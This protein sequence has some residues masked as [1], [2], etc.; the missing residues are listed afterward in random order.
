MR[1]SVIAVTGAS[2]MVGSAL[3]AQLTTGGHRVVRLVR[4]DPR[5]PGERRWDPDGPAPGLLDGT[6]AVVHLA[7]APIAGRF[8]DAHKAAVRDSRVGPT[9]RLAQAAARAQNGPGV[10][11]SA[12]AIGYYGHHRTGELLDE[13]ASPGA[14][15]L[16]GV[17]R[18]WEDAAEPAAEA[19]LRTVQ[20]RTGIVQ[21]PLGGTLRLQRPLFTAGLGGRL[22]SGRQWLSWIDLDDLVDIYHRALYDARLRGP[23]NATAPGAVTAAE[24]AR[25][26]AGVLRR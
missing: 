14:D 4:G 20:V 25:T 15:F 6:D 8:T 19:G 5:G 22:G 16:A 11:V 18:E 10:F 26:L 12:S 24:H 23:V 3:C 13:R 1:P 21:S 9:R 17:V 7:G 2:G